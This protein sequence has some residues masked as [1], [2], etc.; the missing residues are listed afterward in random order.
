MDVYMSHFAGRNQCQPF[1]HLPCMHIVCIH[2]MV[3]QCMYSVC[4]IHLY[5]LYDANF[6]GCQ[7]QNMMFTVAH[8]YCALAI[9]V[10]TEVSSIKV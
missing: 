9:V 1:Q 8:M 6:T 4:I 10:A 5:V 7:C 3:L 2:C